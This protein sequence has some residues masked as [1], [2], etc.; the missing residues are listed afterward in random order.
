MVTSPGY[1]I[2]AI[3]RRIPS[4]ERWIPMNNC[5]QAPQMD[6]TREAADAYLESWR[7]DG[8]D[9]DRWAAEVEAA[10]ASFARLIHADPGDVAICTSVSQATSSVASALDYSR[11]R[12]KVVVTEGEFPTVGQVW[13]AQERR[14]ARVAWVPARDGVIPLE[15]YEPVMDEE[16]LLVSACHGYYQSGFK[17]DLVSVVGMA[18]EVGALVYVDAYQTLGTGPLDVG[19]LDVDFLASGALKFL[20]AIPGI[21]FLYVKPSV[22]ET[23]EPAVTGWF[24]RKD[25]F[26]FDPRDLSWAP[27]AR[28]FETGT[29]PVLE[30]Y[31]ARASMDL[32]QEVGLEAMG[33][34]N[35]E[36]SNALVVGGEA[37]GLRLLGTRDAVRKAPTTAFL[38]S[39]DSHGL[40][41]RMRDRGVLA[42][43][44]GPAI[45]LAPHFYST[46]NDV[47]VAL[48]ALEDV[49]KGTA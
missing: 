33:S 41:L 9:W 39:G 11:G 25:P 29:P 6:L 28:R 18:R 7:R 44:R 4:L 42:S 31:V 1:D 34:W 24:G 5:S 45:R 12:R 38:V 2:D 20:L 36:L 23:L 43:A 27:G 46:L 17:Q 37:R 16:T 30:A 49:L 22:A 21:A 10:R 8:M 19:T 40:E 32:L 48:D 3:R 15:G 26:S 13:M 14:G 47:E 35:R